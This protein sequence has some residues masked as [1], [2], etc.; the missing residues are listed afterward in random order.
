MSIKGDSV[1]L[2]EFLSGSHAGGAPY[3]FVWF[4]CGIVPTVVI[5]TE[6]GFVQGTY[7]NNTILFSFRTIS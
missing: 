7:L 5:G 4:Y 1:F 3:A 6:D 2:E